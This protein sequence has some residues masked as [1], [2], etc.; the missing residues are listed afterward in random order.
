MNKI[1]WKFFRDELIE[2][3]ELAAYN[4][5]PYG[6]CSVFVRFREK[7]D[8]NPTKLND[9]DHIMEGVE[10]ASSQIMEKREN[11]SGDRLYPLLGGRDGFLSEDRWCP[12]N[13]YGADRLDA[14]DEI[15]EWL[16]ELK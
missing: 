2:A 16:E 5:E 10:K 11:F 12:L 7:Y 15:I 6:I 3:L 13:L 4:E 8:P 14:V 1:T 9:W